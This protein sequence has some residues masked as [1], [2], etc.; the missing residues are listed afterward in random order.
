MKPFIVKVPL[1]ARRV[2]AA[3][4][5]DIWSSRVPIRSIVPPA[6]EFRSLI[7]LNKRKML[8]CKSSL[9]LL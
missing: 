8:A 2:G 7:A 1:A 5:S 4:V 9:I 3:I 6:A